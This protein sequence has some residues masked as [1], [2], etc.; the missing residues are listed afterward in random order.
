[1][2]YYF[3]MTKLDYFLLCENVINDQQGRISL[4][5]IFDTINVTALPAI[6]PKLCLAFAVYLD[7]EQQKRGEVKF[8]LD[9]LKP[10]ESSL[11]SAE[12]KGEIKP[13]MSKNNV[14]PKLAA[15]LEL[16]GVVFDEVGL[17]TAHLYVGSKLIS[18]TTFEVK[19]A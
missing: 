6:Q 11:L 3:Y 16:A 18:S 17:Y 5:N 9:V 8:K 15:N 14:Q 12:G 2:L 7:S 19:A 13:V 10:S 1:M 4:I